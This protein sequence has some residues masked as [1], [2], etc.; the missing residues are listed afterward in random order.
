MGIVVK[1]IAV[2]SF[3]FWFQVTY[4]FGAH[5]NRHLMKENCLCLV[6]VRLVVMSKLYRS[7]LIFGES[8]CLA[9]HD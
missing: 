6:A 1:G 5:L 7:L 3:A 2:L 4:R 9:W 8:R